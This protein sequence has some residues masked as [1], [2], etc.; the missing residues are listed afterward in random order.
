MLKYSSNQC[1]GTI[2]A[3]IA[4]F[5]ILSPM[6]QALQLD[7]KLVISIKMGPDEIGFVYL[8]FR[9]THFRV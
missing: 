5:T 9:S 3:E 8:K 6:P 1:R 7:L 4:I 2:R